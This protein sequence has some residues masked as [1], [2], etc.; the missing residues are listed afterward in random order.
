[1]QTC[2]GTETSHF[3][4]IL[5]QEQTSA[6]TFDR[7][8]RRPNDMQREVA[9]RHM[10]YLLLAWIN[11]IKAAVSGRMYK[12]Q[13]R[14]KR[15]FDQNKLQELALKVGDYVFVDSHQLPA[16]TSDAAN[17]IANRRYDTLFCR[18]S[19]THRVLSIQ[20]HTV[21]IEKDGILISVSIHSLTLSP[22]RVQVRY[23]QHE[24]T[25]TL[26]SQLENQQRWNF[27]KDG[28]KAA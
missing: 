28:K 13:C 25:H 7:P 21:P 18:V 11:L 15:H 8:A 9:P 17:K 10:Q 19:G 14:Y 4:V 22:K 12:A 6:V 3:N 1:M 2:R 24:T 16:F 27:F 23:N 20:L 26:R 5:P